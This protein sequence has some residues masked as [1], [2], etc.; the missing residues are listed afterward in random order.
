MA[1]SDLAGVALGGGLTMAANWLQGRA[2]RRADRAKITDA[3]ALAAREA[4]LEIEAMD[5]R[6]YATRDGTRV[7]IHPDTTP[8]VRRMLAKSML[9]P[10]DKV[11]SRLDQLG[12]LLLDSNAIGAFTFDHERTVRHRLSEWGRQVL[13]RTCPPA[14][15]HRC[16]NSSSSTKTPAPR[17]ML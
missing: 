15:S 5:T 8:I 12:R 17:Q 4:L 13:G 7:P 16:P 14:G 10:D 3:A 2:Q 11:R 6:W 1:W 9:I